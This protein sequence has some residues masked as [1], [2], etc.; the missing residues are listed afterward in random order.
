MRFVAAGLVVQESPR[1]GQIHRFPPGDVPEKHDRV[2]HA[3]IGGDQQPFKVTALLPLR[4]ANLRVFV[5]FGGY[6]VR[7]GSLP[8][9]GSLD[10]STVLDGDDLITRLSGAKCR[11]ERD[12]EHYERA[13][14]VLHIQHLESASPG[15]DTPFTAQVENTAMAEGCQVASKC[16]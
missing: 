2:G 5:D 16:G 1:R 3:A 6:Q 7:Q 14:N 9:H 4:V 11:R 15:E 8:L 10:R 12:Y 13:K